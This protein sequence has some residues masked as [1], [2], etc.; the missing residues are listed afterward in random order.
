MD[1]GLKT[2]CLFCKIVA[3]E[4]PAEKVFEDANFLAILDIN[5]VHLGHTLLIPKIHA[6]TIF[7]LP[8]DLL[9]KL[10]APLQ[11]LSRAVKDATAADGINVIINNERAAGQLIDHQHTHLIPRFLNDGFKH[12]H[13]ATKPTPEDLKLIAEKI[14]LTL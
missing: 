12:W 8:A 1:T 7:D 6:Q 2:D 9:G 5:P 14:R 3:G 4:I 13:G 11:I 10:G